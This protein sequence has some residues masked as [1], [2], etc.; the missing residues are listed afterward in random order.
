MSESADPEIVRQIRVLACGDP[1][2]ADVRPPLTM[3]FGPEEVLLNM[4]I[5]FRPRLSTQ[6]VENAINRLEREIRSAYP[7]ITRIYIEAE[8]ITS[9][10]ERTDAR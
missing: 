2:V 6:E 3:H 9:R 8:S 1:A 7:E 10:S 4:D 5:Q